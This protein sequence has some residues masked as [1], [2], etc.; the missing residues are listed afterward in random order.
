MSIICDVL[1]C[2]TSVVVR[3]MVSVVFCV[4]SVVVDGTLLSVFS[5]D[6]LVTGI[7]SLAE[8]IV[9]SRKIICDVSLLV[10][11]LVSVVC[12]VTA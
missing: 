9:V 8:E 7:V 6:V 10:G 2:A 4:V 11:M 5:D 12:D 3:T 1:V